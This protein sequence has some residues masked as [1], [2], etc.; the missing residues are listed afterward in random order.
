MAL[1]LV[2]VLPSFAQQVYID[3]LTAPA[4]VVYAEA[5][6]GQQ[7]KTN[8]NLSAIERGQLLVMSQLKTANDLQDKVLKGL[9]E[10]SGTVRNAMTIREIYRTTEDIIAEASEAIRIAADNP[11]Y[12]VFATESANEFKRRASVMSAEVSRI[13]TS[14]ETNMMD[15]GER[16]KLLNYLHT[17][18]RLIY[19]CAFGVKHSIYWARQRGFWR[20]LNPFAA[21]V[22]QDVG[23]MRDV[24]NRAKAM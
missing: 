11:A 9:T 17:E 21:W 8:D 12:A 10:V 1:P 7:Q 18:L 13:L 14:G 4:M 2:L 23:I 19:A 16:Q 5:I 20:S 22:N 24:I 3:V 6:K 15:A